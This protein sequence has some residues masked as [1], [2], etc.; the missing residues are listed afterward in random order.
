MI[1]LDR[2]FGHPDRTTG[3]PVII[4]DDGGLSDY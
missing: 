3:A 2:S 4:N 1:A